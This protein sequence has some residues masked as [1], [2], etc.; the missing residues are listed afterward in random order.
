MYNFSSQTIE[1]AYSKLK[2]ISDKFGGLICIL[3]QLPED[4]E[5][6]ICYEIN[7]R[8]LKQ[9]LNSV[10]DLE[11]KEI[12]ETTDKWYIVFAKNWQKTFYDLFIREK[13]DIKAF[14]IFF[15]RR[16]KFYEKLS[17]NEIILK[18]TKQ[19][20]IE[21]VKND[22]FSFSEENIVVDYVQSDI[23]NEQKKFYESINVS[24]GN[25]AIKFNGSSVAKSAT[26][27]SSGAQIQPFF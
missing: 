15:F 22:W 18:F 10:F 23:E 17:L 7:V 3:S 16:Y 8:G 6:N 5:P 11:S 20:N 13:I 1:L 12:L 14:S 4:I 24:I 25:K 9:V 26:E 27:F 21:S 19:F 2:N